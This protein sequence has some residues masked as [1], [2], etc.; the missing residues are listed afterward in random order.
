M[1]SAGA[2]ASPASIASQSF[3]QTAQGIAPSASRSSKYTRARDGRRFTSSP[4]SCTRVRERSFARR[5]AAYSPTGN[6]P[7]SALPGMPAPSGGAGNGD[8]DIEPR[9]GGRIDVDAAQRTS[10]GPLTVANRNR[11]RR[12]RPRKR[13]PAAA[14]TAGGSTP[15]ASG[16]PETAQ[17][18]PKRPRTRPSGSERPRSRKA[19]QRDGRGLTGTLALGER[20]QAPWHPLPLSELLILIGAIA[21]VV[22][23][24]RGESGLP[25][26]FAGVGA[27]LIGTV[28]VTVREHLSGYRAHTLMLALL[29][30]IALYS[31]VVFLARP[32]LALNIALLAVAVALA[33]FLFKALRARFL[34]ARRK[35]AFGGG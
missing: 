24:L 31:G 20:P 25:L 15:P 19:A 8:V 29:P 23:F 14:R 7:A 28:E 30:A 13:R 33:V 11:G 1:P 6:G 22:G 5:A 4:T 35:G 34:D 9:I 16:E 27:V 18:Q 3:S 32:P 21:T 2:A 17:Q 12:G 26:V 10:A